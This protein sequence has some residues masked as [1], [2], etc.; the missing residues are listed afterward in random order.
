ML[1][2]KIYK[3]YQLS[4]LYNIVP[5]RNYCN[6][7]NIDKV[8]LFK[9]KHNFLKIHFFLQLLLNERTLI[10]IFWMKI[11]FTFS[12]QNVLQFIRP[13]L[14]SFFNCHNPKGIKLVSRMHTDL[15]HLHEDKFKQSFEDSLNLICRCSNDVESCLLL[16][17]SMSPISN[18]KMYPPEHSYEY[19]E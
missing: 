14:N 18:Q 3:N 13:T 8:P 15:S 4:Y 1:F 5:Q 11:V 7:R 9:V 10:L 19:W 2:Y 16:V 17:F 6:T 12:K